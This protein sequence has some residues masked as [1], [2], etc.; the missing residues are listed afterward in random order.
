[1]ATT[2]KHRMIAANS[3]LGEDVL[4][5]GRMTATEQLGQLF[6]FELELFSERTDI[7]L[8]D[9][10]GTNMTV[11]LELPYQRGTRYFNG[12]VTR[13]GYE[14]TRGLRYGVYHAAHEPLAVVS[15][16]HLR[17]PNLP[18]QEGSRHHQGGFSGSRAS[19]ISRMP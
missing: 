2:Q 16:P 19:P 8:T 18:E 13:L 14:G 6:E 7:V 12:I 3:V 15:D 10:L 9:V 1:M 11:R 4:L 5:V 17:L